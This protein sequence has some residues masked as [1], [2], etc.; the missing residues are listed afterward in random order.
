M[1]GYYQSTQTGGLGVTH[2]DKETSSRRD[3]LSLGV[4]TG[5]MTLLG[6]P[7]VADGAQ[8]DNEAVPCSLSVRTFGAV[9]DAVTD[10]TAHSSVP[11]MP[12]TS[13]EAARFTCP[14]DDISSR[15]NSR[16]PAG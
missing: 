15:G 4:A 5:A 3:L 16:S 1:R 8:H 11:S 2:H 9:A 7:R 10:A 14:L 6:T 13:R 12:S